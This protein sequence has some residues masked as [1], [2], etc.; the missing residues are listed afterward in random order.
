MEN[1]NKDLQDRVKGFNEELSPLLKKYNIGIAAQPLIL[2]DGKLAAKP[3]L[4][5]DSKHEAGE[6][7]NLENVEELKA[8]E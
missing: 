2:P 3:V 7:P 4:F 5:D 6:E 1:D 8:S